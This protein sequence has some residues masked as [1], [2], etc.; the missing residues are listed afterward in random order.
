MWNIAQ[1]EIRLVLRQRTYYA[2][3]SMWT[4]ITFF[5]FLLQSTSPSISGYTHITGTVMNLLLYIIPLFMLING[6]FSIANEMENGQFRLVSTYPLSPIFYVVGKIMGQILAQTLIFT[7]SYGLSLLIGL[8]MGISL[9]VKWMIM[10][11]LFSIGLLLFF[12]LI[13][14]VIGTFVSSK[15][16][17]LSFCVFVWFF[18]I[19]LWPTVLVSTLNFVPYSWLGV[20]VKALLFINP[21]EFLRLMFVVQL[22]GGAVFGQAYDGLVE[23]FQQPILSS[24]SLLYYMIVALFISVLVADKQLT[25]RRLK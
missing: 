11:Y 13:G 19:M 18:L 5:L 9:S 24:F 4:V 12:L 14:I 22:G 3:I 6:A 8:V 7:F 1:A 16:Q 23:Q 15:W 10:L 20:I 17:A 25:K 2:F 21:A